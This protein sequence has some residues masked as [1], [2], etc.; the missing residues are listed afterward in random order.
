MQ[1][2]PDY[3]KKFTV[4]ILIPSWLSGMKRGNGN[5]DFC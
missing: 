1:S 4:G 2:N 5:I 3:N